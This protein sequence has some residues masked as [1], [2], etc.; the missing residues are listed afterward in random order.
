MAKLIQKSG[1]IKSGGAAAG[2]MKYIA[3]RENVEKLQGNCPATKNQRQLIAE[4][5]RDFPNAK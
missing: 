5:L 2:Y 3:T 4:L 1:Y